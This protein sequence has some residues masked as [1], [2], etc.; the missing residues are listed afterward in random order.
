MAYTAAQ[1]A[2][3]DRSDR[4]KVLKAFAK[5]G[6]LRARPGALVNLS[7]VRLEDQSKR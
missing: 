7:M 6:P 2:G 5:A 4:N 3:A 1:P